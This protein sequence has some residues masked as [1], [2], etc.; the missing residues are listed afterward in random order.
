MKES[1]NHSVIERLFKKKKNSQ[2]VFSHFRNKRTNEILI[3]GSIA[4]DDLDYRQKKCCFGKRIVFVIHLLGVFLNKNRK[5][6][7]YIRCY[8]FIENN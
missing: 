2:S 5:K 3:I 4:S 8:F 1:C 6:I 7:L